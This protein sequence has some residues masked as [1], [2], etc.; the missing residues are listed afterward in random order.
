MGFD[1]AFEITSF[2]QLLGNADCI[3]KLVQ[4]ASEIKRGMRRTPIMLCGPSGTGKSAAVRVLAKQMDWNIVELNASDYRD[5]ESISNLLVAASQSM[6]LFNRKNLIL[7]DEIDRL[8]PKFDRDAATAIR[9]LIEVSKNPVIFIAN[10]RWDRSISFL[11]N[12]IEYIE[13]KRLPTN[14][15][16]LGLQRIASSNSLKVSAQTIETIAKRSNGD[17]RSAIND[18]LVLDG[19]AEETAEIVGMRDRKADVFNTLD[20]IFLSST[21]TSPIIAAA[22]ADV[23][24]DMLIQWLDENIPKRYTDKRDRNAAFHMLSLATIYNT[25]A[26]RAQYY[27]YWRYMNAFMSSGVALSKSVYPSTMKR[28]EFPKAISSLSKSKEMRGAEKSVAMKLKR[29]LHL[30]MSRMKKSEMKIMSN[31]IRESTERIGK[32]QTYDFFTAKLGL[33]EKEIAWLAENNTGI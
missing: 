18:L 22:N 24:N 9:K 13:F 26:M 16:A 23:D 4:Y 33:D 3:G 17:M 1:T 25:R 20:K 7:L 27:T 28:Y 15:V 21:F 10:D 30:S 5:G 12:S 29:K 32:E 2:D 14:T 19:A 31:V 6:T 11:R 8:I